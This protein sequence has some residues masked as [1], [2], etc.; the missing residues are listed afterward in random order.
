[1]I[2]E[3]SVESYLEIIKNL[4]DKQEEV[5]FAI[6]QMVAGTDTE[7]AN[8]LGYSDINSVRPR[9][10]EL[11]ELGLVREVGKRICSITGRNAIVW[12]LGGTSK[13]EKEDNCLSSTEF[14]K[15]LT[16]IYKCNEFQKQT[17]L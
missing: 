14:N 11:V 3:T 8:Y 17:N 16:T 1:M 12:G 10:F 15:L 2:Q 4:G 6:K 7:I 9:R 13:E 5:L